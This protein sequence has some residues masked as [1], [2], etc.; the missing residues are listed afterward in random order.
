MT[1]N[2]THKVEDCPQIRSAQVSYSDTNVCLRM[3]KRLSQRTLSNE[4]PIKSNSLDK[5][6]HPRLKSLECCIPDDTRVR[7]SEKGHLEYWQLNLF[8]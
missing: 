8:T 2:P 5:Y 6:I 4:M 1:L 7:Q 3:A